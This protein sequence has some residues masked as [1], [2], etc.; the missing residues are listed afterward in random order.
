MGGRGQ[1]QRN[2]MRVSL[3]LGSCPLGLW[4]GALALRSC[5]RRGTI[6]ERESR[7]WCF[8]GGQKTQGRKICGNRKGRWEPVTPESQW[9]RQFLSVGRSQLADVGRPGPSSWPG[10]PRGKRREGEDHRSVSALGDPCPHTLL[11]K[12][13]FS[14]LRPPGCSSVPAG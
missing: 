5:Q 1:G 12:A 9:G 11:L 2:R 14:S 6:S 4:E 13:C 8:L 7:K 10:N 3:G